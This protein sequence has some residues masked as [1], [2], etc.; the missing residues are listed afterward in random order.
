MPLP[1]WRHR[2]RPVSPGTNSWQPS[3]VRAGFAPGP[4]SSR[5]I[6]TR[7]RGP[8][9]QGAA[10]RLSSGGAAAKALANESSSLRRRRRRS[11]ERRNASAP[12]LSR[13][14]RERACDPWT[15]HAAASEPLRLVEPGRNLKAEPAF[16]VPSRHLRLVREQGALCLDAAREARERAPRPH[17][18][19]AG[20]D[21]GRRIPPRG[22]SHRPR[23]PRWPPNRP[24]NLAV[25]PRLGK[26]NAIQRAPHRTLEL[27][28]IQVERHVELPP[29]AP[30]VLLELPCGPFQVLAGGRV[31]YPA[32]IPGPAAPPHL[33]DAPCRSNDREGADRRLD[34]PDGQGWFDQRCHSAMFHISLSQALNST[35]FSVLACAETTPRLTSGILT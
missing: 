7:L 4:R 13:L 10:R 25:T 9:C 8:D 6:A 32:A 33:P 20:H 21:D 12:R 30:E 1:G 35:P 31:G 11:S 23:R 34:G 14:R 19:V 27:R 24:C 18:P 5:T 29:L 17:H 16:V 2:P 28:A 26:G 15:A 3:Q 22:R